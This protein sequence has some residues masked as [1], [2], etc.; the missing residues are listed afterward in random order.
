M[1]FFK[2]FKDL[3][4]RSRASFRTTDSSSAEGSNG[5]VPTAKSTSTLNSS[6]GAI[7]PPKLNT[8]NGSSPNLTT[9]KSSEISPPPIPPSRPPPIPSYSNR[10]SVI[11]LVPSGSSSTMRTAV[12]DIKP[13]EP[14][15][16]S[17]KNNSN[18]FQKI[19]VVTGQ[20]GPDPDAKQYDGTL[21]IYHDANG[22]VCPPTCW[23]VSASY[24]KALVYLTPG[25]NNLRLEFT[26]PTISR[27]Q[28][29][30]FSSETRIHYVP[31]NNAPPL[32]LVILLGSDSPGTFDAVPER[33]Q[34]EGNGLD[35]AI[36]K[37]RMAAH[38]WQAFTA[39][40][41]FRWG[42][43]RRSFRFDEEWQTSTVSQRDMDAGKMKNEAKV[44]IVR[45]DRTV[46]QLRDIQLAQQYTDAQRKGEL[47]DIAKEAVKRHFNM[48]E[49]QKRYAAVLLLDSHWDT[50]LELIRGHA[51]LG[52][53]SGDLS[54][55]IF[56]SQA[57]QSYPSCIEEVQLAFTDC[58]KTDTSH[59]ANDCNESG[60]NW[61]A[62]NIGIGAHMHEVGHLFGCPHQEYG[63][64][65]RDYTSLNRTFVAREPYSTRTKSQ[66]MRVCRVEDECKWH[67]LDALRFLIH[68][69]FRIPGDSG[70]S[71]DSSISYYPVENGKLIVKSP[72]GIAFIEIYPEGTPVGEMCKAYIE[73]VRNG[74]VGV[75][76][77]QEISITE[78][79]L[80]ERISPEFKNKRLAVQIFSNGFGKLTIENFATL[81]TKQRKASIPSEK[82]ILMKTISNGQRGY[83]S[84]TLGN[85][86]QDGS[87][88]IEVVLDTS[89]LQT[90][91]LRS[92]KI[93][94]G[95][96]V[97]GLEF[98][99]EDGERQMFG[100]RGGTPGGDEYMLGEGSEFPRNVKA[101]RH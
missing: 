32:D 93:Y 66:G 77:P 30:T 46:A 79:D 100:K 1:P 67:R 44:H 35:V 42:F 19:I 70:L 51:A 52:G 22:Q 88:P 36:R 40:N 12:P 15:I 3:R 101:N 89:H 10:N 85:G 25:W 73:F 6:Y 53:S 31:L 45:S 90:K 74:P 97:D 69:C 9:I 38:L 95:M 65:L 34:R 50:Q 62:A 91:L 7:T 59:V 92:I 29:L 33:I 11:G 96:A 48:S 83:R 84:N 82:N 57:L 86:E 27:T 55:A 17:I 28:Q 13:H 58:T 87:E 23:L 18:V 43:G 16:R 41:M 63:V 80:R 75:T 71:P 21:T 54:L 78:N 39:E 98:C 26:S 20:I 81:F 61:E 68:P 5:T 72:T 24:F 47:F 99:Y 8:V 60:S 64:M 4:R 14:Y 56:G 2:D 76:Y 37:Y 94:H 49:G